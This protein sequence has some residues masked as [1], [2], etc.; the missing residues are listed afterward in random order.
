VV[1]GA[2]AASKRQIRYL[3]MT[4]SLPQRVPENAPGDFYVQAG[5][6]T[7]CC[8]VH[9]EAP[10]LLN[11]PEQPF[12]ECFFRRQPETPAEIEQAISAICVSEMCALRYGGTDPTIVTKL[13]EKQL[14][15][16]CDH[17]PEGQA[18]INHVPAPPLQPRVSWWR[19][20]F[21]GHGEAR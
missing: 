1:V 16:Q 5:L 12:E 10:N 20:L 11:D 7:R 13:R 19:K 18:W 8:L 15:S 17:T 14:A 6:C 2:A 9:G 3:A 4:V 21:H